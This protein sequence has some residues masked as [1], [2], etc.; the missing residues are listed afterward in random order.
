[1]KDTKEIIRLFEKNKTIADIKRMTGFS[2]PYIL[3]ILREAGLKSKEKVMKYSRGHKNHPNWQGGRSVAWNGYVRIKMPDHPRALS[4][5]YV[6]E[7]IVVAEKKLGRP[8]RY[9]RKG[10]P[11]N[12]NVHHINGNKLD[13]RPCNLEVFSTLADHAKTE[14][15]YDPMKFP[16]SKE[17]QMYKPEYYQKWYRKNKNNLVKTGVKQ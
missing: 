3:K 1:M 10:H 8:L 13:N 15:Q 5:G 9:F 6:W 11:C 16:Q 17:C 4:N 12:E 14:W 2:R 7:H